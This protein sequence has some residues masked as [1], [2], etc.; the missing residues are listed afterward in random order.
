MFYN[1][2]LFSAF[3]VNL[4]PERLY[5]FFTAC[6]N[7]YFPSLSVLR[8]FIPTV[9]SVGFMSFSWVLICP[10][11]WLLSLAFRVILYRLPPS[12]FNTSKE[13]FL[14]WPQMEA[15]AVVRH[16]KCAACGPEMAP[17]VSVVD[18]L[19][20]SPFLPLHSSLS[21]FYFPCTYSLVVF[22]FLQI[23]SLWYLQIVECPASGLFLGSH[24]YQ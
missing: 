22:S 2:Q 6:F 11:V 20:F 7:Y 1:F 12:S 21:F 16:C 24:S 17:P 8:V 23:L 3:G 10:A 4:S 15:D 14:L 19:L 5:L 18:C 13:S 9:I